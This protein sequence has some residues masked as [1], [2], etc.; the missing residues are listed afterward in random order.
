MGI[1]DPDRDADLFALHY[2][3]LPRINVQLFQ[4]KNAW[5]HHPMRTEH[6]L[7]PIQ[8]WQRGMLSA[9]PRWQQEIVEGFSVPADY[10]IEEDGQFV[11]CF[12]Q[13]SVVIP[14]I[15]VH[16]TFLQ[17]QQL[18]ALYSPFQYS[19]H[20]GADIYVNVRHHILD[21]INA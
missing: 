20:G 13:P 2:V 9:S 15:D 3:F 21:L 4:F 5:N 16:L 8:L 12:D 14:R 6:G 11:N 10:G 7:C 1:L 18:Q 19:C 17:I